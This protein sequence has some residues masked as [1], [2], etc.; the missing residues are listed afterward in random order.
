LPVPYWFIEV[1]KITKT[2][3]S[4]LLDFPLPPQKKLFSS[5][6]IFS[7]GRTGGY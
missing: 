4:R 2:S 7:K 5:S 6:E 1:L 3:G